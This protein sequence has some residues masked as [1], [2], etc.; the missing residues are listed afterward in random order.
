MEPIYPNLVW[1][2][3][4]RNLHTLPGYLLD[5]FVYLSPAIPKPKNG[6]IF[7]PNRNSLQ[8][9]ELLVLGMRALAFCSW[10]IFRCA[11]VPGA[12]WNH[13]TWAIV[14]RVCTMILTQR[15]LWLTFPARVSLEILFPSDDQ[16]YC[17]VSIVNT[18][19][20]ERSVVNS[21]I[22]SPSLVDW[23][24]SIRWKYTIIVSLVL[25]L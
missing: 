9:R 21:W 7:P 13:I 19:F 24:I 23:F 16:L 22:V 11:Y 5:C 1:E 10:D 15:C 4:A 17:H 18:H 3:K 25:L 6:A 14:G 2:S 12:L 20:T 8:T